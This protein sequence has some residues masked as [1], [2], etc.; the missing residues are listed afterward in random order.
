MMRR[1]IALIAVGMILYGAAQW[2]AMRQQAAFIAQMKSDFAGYRV[3][4][5][6]AKKYLF[7]HAPGE[8]PD[9]I[10][11]GH[12]RRVLLWRLSA[13]EAAD[14]RAKHYWM[15]ENSE[16]SLQVPFFA[17]EPTGGCPNFCV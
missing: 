3:E 14:G 8:K 16:R 15:I 10:D 7:L 1:L 17:V 9:G 11:L 4:Y 5:I 12:P 13:T 6:A 2:Y